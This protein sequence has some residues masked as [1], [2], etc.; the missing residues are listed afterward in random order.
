MYKSRDSEE[1]IRL[2][3]CRAEAARFG[4]VFTRFL[5]ICASSGEPVRR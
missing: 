2:N 1:Y 5:D 4:D 3:D